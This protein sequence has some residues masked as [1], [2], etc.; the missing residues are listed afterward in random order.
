MPMNIGIIGLGL[1]GGSA[2]KAISAYTGHRV[3]AMDRD[4]KVMDEAL[5]CGA[6]KGRLSPERLEECHVVFL[7]LYPK[8]ALKWAEVHW[9]NIK[10]GAVLVDFC[11]VKRAVVPRLSQLAGEGGFLYLGGHPIKLRT[12]ALN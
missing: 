3:Y 9:R 10:K 8:A 2:A 5:A 4:E 1:I 11:G 7:A 12:Q 6:I